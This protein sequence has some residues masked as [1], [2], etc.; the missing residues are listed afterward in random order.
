MGQADGTSLWKDGGAA[1][2]GSTFERL[3][4]FARVRLLVASF[5]EKVLESPALRPYFEGIEMRR[6][7]DH[8]TKFMTAIM[9]GPA[10]YTDEHIGRA[11]AHLRVSADDFDE[12]ASLFVETLEDYE[13]SEADI[14]RLSAH[15]AGLRPSIVVGAARGAVEAVR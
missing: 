2:R 1:M 7:I 14:E 4:G 10:S 13:I 3:G 9:G 15:V 11:H 8:Q 12:M 5:Y 6:L